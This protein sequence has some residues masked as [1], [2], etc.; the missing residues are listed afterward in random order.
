MDGKGVCGCHRASAGP[1]TSRRSAARI[2]RRRSRRRRA[3][4]GRCSIDPK[5]RQFK[6]VNICFD[7]HHVQFDKDETLYGNGVFS[8]AIG[9][10]NTRILDETGDEAKA[11]GWCRGY[12]DLNQ[13][14]KVDPAVDRQIAVSVIYSVIPH[15]TDGVRHPGP[16]PGK[17]IRIDPKTRWRSLRAAVRSAAGVVGYTP[18]GIDVD[19]NGVIWTRWR[20]ADTSPVSTAASARPLQ[21]PSATSG[22]HCREGWTLYP[23]PGPRFKGVRGDVAV[24][25]QV[26]QLRR[27]LQHVRSRRQHAVRERHELRF[28][29]GLQPDGTWLVFRVPYPLG[30][31]SR[32]M[33]GRID[34]PKAGWKGGRSTPTMDRMPCGT[35]KAVSARG[36]PS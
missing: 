11:Q 36:A 10:I 17:I 33:D 15:P 20:A 12:H 4:S 35:W 31:F 23:V 7:T 29:A 2:R 34:D 30:F 21:G 1:R 16:M 26:L 27:P 6:Q 13:D 32:G 8:G 3:A 24:D 19:S 28:A 18:R 9:W 25:F 22:Q 5:T 14:G